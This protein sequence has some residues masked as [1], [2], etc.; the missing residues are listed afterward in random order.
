METAGS[1]RLVELE[2]EFRT[3][4]PADQMHSIAS[5]PHLFDEFP[6]PVVINTA[7]L[8]LAD[9]YR[10]GNNSQRHAIL[11]VIKKSEPHLKLIMNVKEVIQRIIP[12]M[13][14][15]DPLARAI[16]LRM[17]G[18]MAT[19]V[20]DR[21]DVYHKVMY[22]MDSLEAMEVS[23]AVYAA[24]R[25][26]AQSQRF[27]AIISGKLAFMVR[28]SKTPLPLRR[29]LI[30]IFGHM[31]EDITLARLDSEYTVAILR[32]L[33]RLATHSLVDANHQIDLL[34]ER[35]QDDLPSLSG[36]RRISLMCLESLAQAGI[37]FSL[38]QTKA[39]FDIASESKDEKT[40]LRALSTLQK[41]FRL[42]G[43][44][45]TVLLQD[46]SGQDIMKNY[47]QTCLQILERAAYSFSSTQSSE[48]FS[49]GSKFMLLEGFTL[50]SAIVPSYKDA[51]ATAR[52]IDIVD[53]NA[54]E[55]L[56][57]AIKA[58][59]VMMK[60]FLVSVWD[61]R[62]SGTSGR[63]LEN[64]DIHHSKAVLWLLVSLIL[65]EQE[66][67]EL[68]R[69]LVTLMEWIN[70]YKELSGLLAKALLH[71]ACRQPKKV[72]GVQ[73][74]IKTY[75][76]NNVGST[77]THA[78]TLVY[79]ALLE[80]AAL[81]RTSRSASSATEDQ[82]AWMSSLLERFGQ[83][84]ML[85]QYTRNQWELY[86]L[87]R[88]SL[89]AGWVSLASGALKNLDRG[90][91][92]V[93]HKL[94]LTS[95]QTVS[96]I[97]SSLQLTDWASTTTSNA[98]GEWNLDLYSQ[99]QM[100]AKV[101][102]YLEEIEAYQNDRSF[103]VKWCSL[104]HRYLQTCQMAVATLQ[105]LSS[106]LATYRH[107]QQSDID[108]RTAFVV[109]P[110][111]EIALSRCADD[112]NKLA[113]YYTVLRESVS[114]KTSS[115]SMSNS[116]AARQ[117]DTAIEVLQTM[118]LVLGYTIQRLVKIMASV[119]SS[120]KNR[121]DVQLNQ[122]SGDAMEEDTEELQ[123]FDVDPLM[124]PLLYHLKQEQSLA[125]DGG[126][127]SARTFAEVF[128][129]STRLSLAY[130]D[131]RMQ[132]R[133]LDAFEA[134]ALNNAK[135]NL[136][137]ISDHENEKDFGYVYGVSG[138]VVIADSMHGAAMH[139]LVRVGHDELVGEVIR[140]DG[141]KATI[142]VYE[143]TSGLT[144]GD[145][146]LRTGK[147]LSVELGPGLMSNIYDGIQRPLKAISDQ[148]ESIYIPRGISTV[149]LD[150]KITWD[151]V[152]Q[153]FK[154]GDHITGGD[155]YG[156]VYENS[157]KG[158]YTLEDKVLEI[159]FN[160][161]K[162]EFTMMH[163]WP[164][165]SPRP[166]AEKLVGD[167]PLLTGQRVL[168]ALFPCVQGGTTAIPGAFGC[169]KTVISQSLSKYSNSDIIIY[170]GCGE[171][172]NEMAEVLMDFPEL[173]IQVGDRQ[174]S[175]MK[176]TTLVANTSN[177]PVAAREASIYTG[178][179]LSEY[180]RDQGKNVAMM[181]DSTSR[182]AEALREIS[183]RLAEMPADSGYPAYLG[184]RLASF[185]ERA[186]KVVCLGN[187]RREGSVSVVGAVSPPGGDFAD[188]VT[189]STLGI[190]QVF[191][192]LDKKLAQRKHFPSVNWSQSYSKYT[193][194]L[195]GFYEKEDPEFISLRNK[196]REILQEEQD[197]S[198]IVQLVGKSA[199][200]EKDKIVLEVAK[201]INDD[202][203]QQN[204]YSNYD[205]YC[206]FYKTVWM[207]RNMLFFYDQAVHTVESS[208]NVTWGRIRDTLG[209]LLYKLSSMK[210]EDPED[211]EQVLREKYSNLYKEIED[212][213]R[214]F[215]DSN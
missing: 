35:A 20:N 53:A 159:E 174:E 68:E 67:S 83:A 23:A 98:G 56:R 47:T 34:L 133:S 147:P 124:L 213:F 90:I 191:W 96:M 63:N 150:R 206:P 77:D 65:E 165:R 190:V 122:S 49:S 88:Y 137:R 140:I 16:T 12:I 19:I 203:L 139:E 82:E 29:R 204:G 118:C 3:H 142:Q 169:G 120:T 58:V 41:I 99:Q 175:I 72:Q 64:E 61:Q 79:R 143:E 177:M 33:T 30:R 10:T 115:S 187:P 123:T 184:A 55:A 70:T 36:I 48:Q 200:A 102:G 45:T 192:G 9:Y 103:H 37:E 201:L 136:I 111:D 179:T 208:Q 107:R 101:I 182:W 155:A 17:L 38:V 4:R 189:Q 186:G 46:D 62:S 198:E 132:G 194:V 127:I 57:T 193:N 60:Q 149:A 42:T 7:I 43:V 183:G 6:S 95:L 22:S 214:T 110:G 8:K 188:P 112:F 151:F 168:D 51:V 85:E 125:K 93:P 25:I 141:H 80:S 210:F 157:L 100:Y 94:W 135:K 161:E 86:Q 185:Y 26:C 106:S 59:V 199:L 202:F 21:V 173:S 130:V 119:G 92:S 180:F 44:M 2:T 211:G 69:F 215:M 158:S 66:D 76:D 167:Y 145:P 40:V 178:I 27:C 154:V 144:V 117:S 74:M 11:Q 108:N 89:Q 31:F 54:E 87:A 104:R 75:L 172:G 91:Q 116:E 109:I 50:F 113:H 212:R 152:P 134:G 131:E 164:V 32:T 39:I 5:F 126:E 156:A 28:D 1:K 195:A 114:L 166:V 52:E 13:N 14:S 197:L 128:R 196:T 15:I 171:R 97:E 78:F 105:F 205:R 73:G 162:Q 148:S 176:R 207:L 84:D 18:C 129:A 160:G 81:Y 138:P 163:T 181:A 121:G 153:S 170:V 71:V 24:D 209:D 146:V